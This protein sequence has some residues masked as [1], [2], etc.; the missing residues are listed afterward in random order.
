MYCPVPKYVSKGRIIKFINRKA[1]KNPTNNIKIKLFITK[2][3]FINLC[4]YNIFVKIPTA[5]ERPIT[6]FAFKLSNL[7]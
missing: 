7:N 5:I 6:N 4:K 2:Y 3:L 1:N